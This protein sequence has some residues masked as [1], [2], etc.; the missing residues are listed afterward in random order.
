MSTATKEKEKVSPFSS[1]KLH[2][3]WSFL[4]HGPQPTKPQATRTKTRSSGRKVPKFKTGAYVDR[5]VH[6]GRNVFGV[7]L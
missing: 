2:S 7:S 5:V 3:E 1:L 4:R 6:S